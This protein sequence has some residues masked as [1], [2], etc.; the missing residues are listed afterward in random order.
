MIDKEVRKK[1]LKKHL[2]SRVELI[3]VWPSDLNKEKIESGHLQEVTNNGVAVGGIYVPF[4][5]EHWMIKRIIT[6]KGKIIFP[7]K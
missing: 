2:N 7:I 5:G 3:W 1:E 4:Q 6:N